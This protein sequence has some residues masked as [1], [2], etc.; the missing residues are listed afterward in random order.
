[1]P[2][3]IKDKVLGVISTYSRSPHHF[4]EEEL[5]P[6]SLFAFQ[7]AIAIQEARLYEDVHVT[8][9]NTIHSLVL[10]MEARD[11]YTRGHADRVTR[12]SIEIAQ[13]L[14]LPEH[15]IE[16][17]R[18]AGEVHDVGKIAISDLILNKPGKLTPT[19]RAAVEVHPVR[20]AEMLEPLQFLKSAI[21]LVRHHHERYD[22]KGYPDG[23]EKDRIPLMARI[24]AC[25]DS[26]DA[27]T[28]ERPYRRCKLSTEDALQEIK[29]NMGSQF[30][31]N[32]ARIFIKIIKKI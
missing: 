13:E 22:G 15:D 11:P 17:L 2:M 16:I 8:Y 24:M 3:V 30:D 32:V 10:A 5:K 20:G 1:M 31:P 19:E 27:M 4:T 6:L 9:F 28:S 18:Y 12:Y 21:P 14:G 26:F 25:A 29:N 7:A 23:L